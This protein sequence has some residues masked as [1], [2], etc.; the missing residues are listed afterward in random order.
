LKARLPRGDAAWAAV[1]ALLL[2]GW[3]ASGLDLVVM[4]ALGTAAGFPWRNAWLTRD[5][6]HE[7]GR[8]AS[9]VLLALQGIDAFRP[10]IDGPSRRE[11]FTAL[12]ATLACLVAVP[13]L[14]QASRTSCPWD[15]AS[16]GGVARYVPHWVVGLVDGGAGHCFP[17]GH[18]VAAFAFFGA[19]FA[20]RRRRPGPA[21]A[22][23]A[24]VL[25][26]GALFGAAQVM[27]GAHYPSH[28]LWSAWLC[29]VI[30]AATARAMRHGPLE[31]RPMA[32]LADALPGAAAHHGLAPS[33][34]GRK[35]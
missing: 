14:K 25:A 3:D 30:C 15:L 31:P 2:V 18:A 27:R 4:H 32:H 21:R 8:W 12:F 33:T 19:Y 24:G 17:S 23:L 10:V 13:A 28:V 35:P 29:W 22:W 20:L 9:G 34:R 26:A 7:G 11:R 6:L 5:L 1:A 16:F